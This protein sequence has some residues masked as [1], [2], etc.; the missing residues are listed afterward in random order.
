MKALERERS[1]RRVAA[2]CSLALVLVACSGRAN[3][4]RAND[5]QATGGSGDKYV[6]PTLADRP[7]E[8]LKKSEVEQALGAKFEPGRPHAASAPVGVVGMQYCLFAADLPGDPAKRQPGQVPTLV[9]IGLTSAFP[10]RA[11]QI[12]K[13]KRAA[14]LTPAP[15]LGTGAVFSHSG[16]SDT[17]VV[18]KGRKVVGVQLVFVQKDAQR[19]AESLIRKALARL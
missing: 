7:C 10:E 17:V 2:S 1:W 15:S 5:D 3:D 18:L 11:F 13:E 12:Y 4:D 14:E 9:Y 19:I 8:L 16:P 6:D